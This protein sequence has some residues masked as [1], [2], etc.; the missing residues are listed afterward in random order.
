MCKRG[1][2]NDDVQGVVKSKYEM[3]M[4]TF[5]GTEEET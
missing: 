5:Y 2:W 1:W 3:Y 4:L